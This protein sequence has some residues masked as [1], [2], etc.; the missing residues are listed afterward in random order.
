MFAW[1]KFSRLLSAMM[2]IVL[3]GGIAGSA[4]AQFEGLINP[5]DAFEW[6]SDD[7]DVYI[8]DV[9]TSEEWRWVGHPGPNGLADSQGKGLGYKNGSMLEDK[10]V[11]IAYKIQ[12]NDGT[13][14]LM[15]NP[16]FTQDVDLE[17]D[18]DEVLLVLC[19]SGVRAQAAADDL[20]DL[21]YTTYNIEG[22]FE[23]HTNDETYPGPDTGY[24]DVDGWV[25]AKL[26]YSY[27]PAGGYYV[28][29]T[30]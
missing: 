15:M 18:G 11:N 28:D 7:K 24:L 17:F 13:A 1:A 10:V 22:G 30:Q 19:R 25:N 27:D 3:I 16:W 2:S 23:G 9:R 5:R 12:K 14:G 8:L 20:G 4:T 21:G 26:P 6:A 29:Y